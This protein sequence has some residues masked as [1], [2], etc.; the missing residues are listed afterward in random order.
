MKS[1]TL[2]FEYLKKEAF[3]MKKKIFLY[4]FKNAAF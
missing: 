2:K 4:S 3:Q 1:K